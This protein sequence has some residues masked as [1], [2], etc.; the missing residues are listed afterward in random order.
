MQRTKR[1]NDDISVYIEDREQVANKYVLR[2]FTVTLT[3]YAIAFVLNMLDIFVVDKAIMIKSFIPS[4]II[5]LVI[6]LVS[7]RAPLSKPQFKYFLMAGVLVVYTI[8]GVYITYHVTLLAILPFLYAALYS[9]KR[10]MSYVYALTVIS[11]FV[12]VYCGYFFGLCDANMALLTTSNLQTHSVDGVFLLSKVNDNVFFTLLLYYIFPRCLMYI[13]YIFVSNNILRIV[14]GSL[15]KAKLSA[16]LEKAREE[17]ERANKAKSEFLAKMSHEIRT[18][19]NA[20]LGMNEMILREST[21]E[22]IL[23]YADDIKNSSMALL[24]IIN[25]ILDSS[26]IESGMMEL[27]EGDYRLDALLKELYH[28]VEIRSREKGLQLIFDID[29][30]MPRGYFGDDKRIRQVLLNLLTNAVKYTEQGTVTLVVNCRVEQEEAIIHFA[31]RDTGI[32]IKEEDIGKIYDAYQ[33]FDSSRNKNVEGTGLGMKIAKQFLTLMESELV[34]QSEYEKGSEFSFDI[35]QRIVDTEPI[36]DFRSRQANAGGTKSKQTM[37]VAP[38]KKLLVVDDNRMNRKVFKALLKKT[39]MQIME[40]DS[41]KMC[42]EL[43]RQQSF[44]IVFLDHM[45]P[46]MDGIETFHIIKE[47]KLCEGIPIIMLTANAIM[48][49]RE[50]YLEEGFDDFLSKPIMPDELEKM[51]INYL[52]V[53]DAGVY[54][55]TFTEDKNDSN[56]IELPQ[57]D[58]FD[59]GYAKN[60]LRD[61]ELLPKILIDFHDSL[62]PLKQKLESLFADLEKEEALQL[63]RIEVHALKSTSATVGA[64]LLSKVARLQEVACIQGDL[65][66]IRVLHPILL[67]EMEKHKERIATIIP[68]EEKQEA[69]SAHMVFF[70]M[71]KS[72]LINKDFNSADLIC[73]EI[74]K[75]SYPAEMQEV[76]D[77]LLEDVLNLD[78]EAALVALEKIK[79]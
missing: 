33:R 62:N 57:L 10:I 64:L 49:D 63:Y 32:G 3:I 8:M 66:R 70:E 48:G 6:L 19:V 65:D 61:E 45:M 60:I 41:G 20:V 56:P 67:D 72:S 39:Q 68:K 75:Y 17:A 52:A 43:L 37:F 36:G 71:L 31:V 54:T 44:D 15:E 78:S 40:A 2:C 14:S 30:T 18:P 22:D 29:T 46:E 12:V 26:K 73:A 24:N 59:F 38:D 42:L 1:I 55:D 79:R 13:A 4:A 53:T 9:S 23:S 11:T 50:R 58:E 21:N 76:I 25:E 51:L 16:E 69:G 27:V 7:R 35:I 74:K 28:M 34:I 47:E 77:I 5:Y